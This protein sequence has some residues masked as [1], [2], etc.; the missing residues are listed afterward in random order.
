MYLWVLKKKKNK[1]VKEKML[2]I[3]LFSI[4]HNVFKVLF[5]KMQDCLA[6][7]TNKDMQENLTFGQ[8]LCLLV[9]YPESSLLN[10]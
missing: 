10:G 4:F 5:P 7:D 2:L 1:W 6:K 8:C 9:L 3:S